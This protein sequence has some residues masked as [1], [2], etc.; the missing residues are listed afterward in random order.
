MDFEREITEIKIRN[1]RVE[2][3][4]AW[5]ISWTRKILVS[6]LTYI[7]AYSWLFLIKEP[8]AVLKSFVPVL[9]YF[10]STLSIKFIKKIWQTKHDVR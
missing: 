9:G 3:D 8:N 2:Q 5:E 10:I 6:L 1:K 4:K 7:F